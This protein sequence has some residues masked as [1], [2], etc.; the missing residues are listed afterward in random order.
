MTKHIPKYMLV[1]MSAW[2]SRIV[3]A[4]VQLASI[5]LLLDS[6]GTE[7]YAIY[8]LLS[9]LVGWYSLLDFGLGASLQNFVAEQRGK[10][11]CY[12]TFV[13]TTA[14]LALPMLAFAIGMLYLISPLL[15]PLLL[16][17][18]AFSE[19]EKIRLFF[20]SGSLFA[21]AAIGSIVY[22]LWYAEHKGYLANLL[23]ALASLLGLVGIYMVV[24]SRLE[25]KL[26]GSILAFNI[27][28]AA[29]S[30]LALMRILINTRKQLNEHTVLGP[31]LRRAFRFWIFS[32]M[33]VLTLQVDY[34]IMSQFLSAQEV[35]VYSLTTRIFGIGY[36]LFSALLAALWSSF[37]IYMIQNR[38]DEIIIILQ[39]N[40]AIGLVGMI[41]FSVIIALSMSWIVSILAPN[42]T[43]LHIPTKF[44]IF[45]GIYQLILIWVSVFSTVLQSASLL[46]VFIVW[47]P[48]QA[49]I[50]IV[51]QWFLA[52]SFGVY[53]IISG[54]IISYLVIPVWYLPITLRRHM[55]R[56]PSNN[57]N[58]S[59]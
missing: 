25:E 31:L 47:T 5:R 37:T 45:V 57:E 53:G 14:L 2:S 4:V 7:R 41:T 19:T 9:S 39:R 10:A 24:N 3:T 42:S 21:V 52:Q 15:A 58:K 6:L 20:L 43:G 51:G 13:R 1:T 17:K 8:L 27:P 49:V 36:F 26:L 29:L 11:E 44:I 38:W 50:S 18:A 28:P 35:V 16:Q 34:L 55:I 59:K 40:L 33:V 12:A 22:K 54:L 56:V 30:L 23:P 48:V 32:S 46:R